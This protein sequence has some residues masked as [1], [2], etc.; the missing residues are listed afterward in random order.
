MNPSTKFIFLIVLG[1]SLSSQSTKAQFKEYRGIGDDILIIEKP[2][3]DLP[4]LLVINGNKGSSHFSITS[5]DAARNYVDL[6]VNTS[7]PYTGIVAIDLPVGTNTKMLEISATG[8]WAVNV[9]SIGAAPKISTDSPKSDS[10][11][12]ILWIE[13]DASIAT[14]SGNSDSSHFSVVAYDGAGNYGDLLVNT[15]DAYRGKVMIPKGTLLLQINAT[16]N[17]TINLQ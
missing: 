9:Y 13:G 2:D 5:Y 12:N 17:W 15:S 3:E 11:D 8:S 7:E 1:I 16:G 14:I 4:T 6:L 10:G